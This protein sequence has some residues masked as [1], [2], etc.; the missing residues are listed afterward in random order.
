MFTNRLNFRNMV[1]I[2]I[3]LTV[4][5]FFSGC[6]K[7]DDMLLKIDG[8][9][10]DNYPRVDGSTSTQP[11]NTLIAC[12]LFGWRYEWKSLITGNGI[13][14]LEP[15]REDIPNNF[16]GEKIKSTQTHNSII[17]LIDNKTAL[18]ST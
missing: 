7:E 12:K 14:L 17:N 3:C 18:V 16:F 5:P 13:W 11:L 6:D 2:A 15:N 10:I 9:T 4:I 8:L 1:V